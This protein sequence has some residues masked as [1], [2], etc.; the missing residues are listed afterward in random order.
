MEIV[1]D[2][3]RLNFER[4]SKSDLSV[5]AKDIELVKREKDKAI[6]KLTK[7]YDKVSINR[8]KM[9]VSNEEI[10][11]AYESLSEDQIQ[12]IKNAKNRIEGFCKN[13]L[14][15]AWRMANDIGELGEIIVPIERVGCYIPG[16]N[17]PLP[18]T[19]LMTVV[20]AK[21]AG[22]KE[23]VICTPPK[24]KDD[25]VIANEAIVVAADVLGVKEIFKV[26]GIQAIAAMTYGTETIPKVDKI[27]G[28]GNKYV[29]VAKKL[30][31]GDVDIDF[32]AG[33]TE[34][35][36]IADKNSK[37]EYIAADLIAQ[38]EHDVNACPVLVTDSKE[39]VD[40]VKVEIENQLSDLS[41][42][43]IAEKS[44]KN[45]GKIIITKT[46]EECFEIAN[47]F[48]PEHLEIMIE[49]ANEYLGRIQNAGSIFIGENSVEA[50][51]DYS[52]GP[53][54]VLPTSG[55]ARIR[56]GL[57]VRDFIKFVSFQNITKTG[58]GKLQKTVTTLAR[59]ES[60]E[61]HARS[62]EKRTD[63]T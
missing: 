52:S 9:R 11:K 39:I 16:G 23:I 18:S 45:N 12:E 24:I 35:L 27:V 19:V 21:I 20:P 53:N 33:P 57:S 31:Y 5:T 15:E 6:I 13:Q 30:V 60:L 1:R 28:P 38:A 34:V 29:S 63:P 59:L 22:V 8:D 47:E 56:G 49:N 14:P 62:V 50:L 54:H 42:K 44:L 51:G 40:K 3:K 55:L 17:Y 61:G 10:K 25:S 46:I 36:I 26:G 4:F 48:A 32:I 37:P 2:Y 43:R 41:T 58:I 7:K